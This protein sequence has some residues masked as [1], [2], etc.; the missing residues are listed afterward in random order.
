VV[1]G[2]P[3]LGVRIGDLNGR[4]TLEAEVSDL[5]AVDLPDSFKGVPVVVRKLA[6]VEVP[7]GIKAVV[8][9]L[10]PQKSTDDAR[11]GPLS[12]FFPTEASDAGSSVE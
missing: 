11:P 7:P 10:G 9:L 5:N 12:R 2:N 6:K 8:D 1:V 3:V 4:E